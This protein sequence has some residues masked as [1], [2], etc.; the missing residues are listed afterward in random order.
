LMEFDINF[1]GPRAQRTI[2][3][4]IRYHPSFSVD[5]LGDLALPIGQYNSTQP[6]NLGQNRWYGRV[7]APIVWQLGPWVPGKRTTLEF[8]PTVW[9]FG[10]NND[11]VGQRLKTDPLFQLDGHLTRDLTESFWAVFE[12]AW[13]AGGK[14]TID[15]VVGKSRNNVGLGLTVGYHI[16]DNLGLTVGYKSTVNHGAPDALRLNQFTVSLVYGWNRLVEGTKR[17]KYE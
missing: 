6:V 1:L 15:D 9:L 7:G 4:S 10:P 16:S 3:D 14:P 17:L 12:T 5:L 11:F 13:Y 2:P 8:L